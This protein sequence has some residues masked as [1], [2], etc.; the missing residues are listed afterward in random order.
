VSGFRIGWLDS[1][2]MPSRIHRTENAGVST[3]CGHPTKENFDSGQWQ[4]VAEVPRTIRGTGR[5]CR[6]CF[7]AGGKTLPWLPCTTSPA[8]VQG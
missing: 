8:P 5:Y 7:A 3:V 6:R 1:A 4:H 2:R